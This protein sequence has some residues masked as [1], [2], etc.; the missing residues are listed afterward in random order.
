MI[1]IAVIIDI[2]RHPRY[3]H[4]YWY[5]NY[6]HVLCYSVTISVVLINIISIIPMIIIISVFPGDF[7][8][9]YKH[10]QVPSRHS[11]LCFC[12]VERRSSCTLDF[13]KHRLP[14]FPRSLDIRWNSYKELVSCW[15][16]G[17]DWR[18]EG[19]PTTKECCWDLKEWQ[20]M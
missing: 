15:L 16:N 4:Q 19:C 13:I 17:A 5:P 7:F 11:K 14:G 20:E 1:I 3:H 6:F 10:E 18:L 9:D 8:F 12:C 2:C